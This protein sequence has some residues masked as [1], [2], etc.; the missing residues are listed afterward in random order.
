VDGNKTRYYSTDM[1]AFSPVMSMAPLDAQIQRP[2]MRR[3]SSA[4]NLLTSFKPGSLGQASQTGTLSS[5]AGLPFVTAAPTP[6]GATPMAREWDAQSLHSDSTHSLGVQNGGGAAPQGTSVEML[7]EL[8]KKR[9]ITL[10][11]LRNV[12][13]GCVD[14]PF[15]ADYYVLNASVQKESLVPYYYAHP[16]RTRSCVL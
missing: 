10:T 12:H 14:K 3:K 8:V 11:Y 1:S 13:E 9:I 5:V 7:R 16:W 6:A 2:N 4:Q 15:S